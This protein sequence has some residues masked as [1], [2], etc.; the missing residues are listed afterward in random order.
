MTWQQELV[1]SLRSTSDLNAYLLENNTEL[2][3][4][5]SDFPIF[6]PM[7]F[8]PRVLASPVLIKQFIPTTEENNFLLQ[9]AGFIDPIADTKCQVT[10]QIVH[11]YHNRALFI[12]T[13]HCPVHCRYCFR[14]NELQTNQF[15][16]KDF[17]QSLSYL[18][19]H[20]EIEEIIFTGGDPLI[21]TNDKL[22]Y[23][24]KK[25]QEIPSIKFIRFHTRMPII[26]PSRIDE[27]FLEL[28]TK[29][30]KHFQKINMIIHTNHMDEFD[31]AVN[32]S[33]KKLPHFKT[34][35]VLLKG[36]NDSVESLNQLF[37]H[38]ISLGGDPYYLHHPDK[39]KGGMHFFLSTQEG[40]EI[41]QELRQILPGWA[42][43]RYVIDNEEGTGKELVSSTSKFLP[44]L[45]LRIDT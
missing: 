12:P 26:I 6:L 23:F 8:M 35:S 32:E 13:T 14:R 45:A 29:Y 7:K 18:Q 36:V 44:D 22:D 9:D 20:P 25:F 34:Q 30:Q 11:R 27:G 38:I 4:A 16:M 39:V 31:D 37:R 2:N 43:P 21:L 1:F 42:L 19:E 40:Q 3:I 15:S 5:D 17:A 24:L 10:K 41:Y 33:L 28:L